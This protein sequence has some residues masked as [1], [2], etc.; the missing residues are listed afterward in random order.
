MRRLAYV[1]AATVMTV[2]LSGSSA[3]AFR[4]V[5]WCA[6]DPVIHLLGTKVEIVTLIHSPASAVSNVTYTVQVPANAGDVKVTYPG[7]RK[8]PTTVNIG[9]TGSEYASGSFTMNVSVT[10]TG[11]EGR[12]TITQVSGKGVE[13]A[14]YWGT[15]NT[16]RSFAVNVTTK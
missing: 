16:P 13:S 1:V 11:P 10:V 3:Y 6:E 2:I 8:I 7:G 14:T 15:T 5:H 9:Y 4:E 12:E